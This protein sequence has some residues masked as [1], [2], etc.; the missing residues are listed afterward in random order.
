MELSQDRTRNV[1]NYLL[2][3]TNIKRY[4]KWSQYLITANGLSSS[5]VI[6]KNGKED[7]Y[8]SQRVDF[9]VVANTADQL[10]QSLKKL[11]NEN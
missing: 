8:E 10:I 5:K 2:L 3:N 6:I 7:I 1:L 9:R 11:T 4:K